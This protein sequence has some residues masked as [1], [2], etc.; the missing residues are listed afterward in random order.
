MKLSTAVLCDLAIAMQL[1]AAGSYA[2]AAD[3]VKS[4]IKLIC[5]HLLETLRAAAAA[6]A[7][8]GATGHHHQQQQQHQQ[9]QQH[10]AVLHAL[11]PAVQAVVQQLLVIG[12]TQAAYVSGSQPQYKQ[13]S[14]SQ[15]PNELKSMAI[16]NISW[17]N[18]CK[19]LLETPVES[20]LC[21]LQLQQLKQGLQCALQQLLLAIRGT[22]VA[23]KREVLAR[24]WLQN[25]QR[26][27]TVAG[28]AATAS[29][30]E[31]LRDTTVELYAD[32]QR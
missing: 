3:R 15:I 26:L 12:L 14:H 4:C 11:L 1:I 17:G 31:L 20:R 16:L 24:F 32:V 25:V 30:L 18:L 22:Q 13:I 8:D 6:V 21:I 2:A 19:L 10:E 7:A 28:T 29:L 27:V 5:G 9:K 23:D